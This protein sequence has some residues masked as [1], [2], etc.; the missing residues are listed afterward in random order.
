V[1]AVCN[2]AT[3]QASPGDRLIK[4]LTGSNL[5]IRTVLLAERYAARPHRAPVYRAERAT[6]VFDNECRII[7]DPDRD[8]RLLLTPLVTG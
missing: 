7:L 3:P 5:W 8:A 1:L 4:A 6:M 2:A